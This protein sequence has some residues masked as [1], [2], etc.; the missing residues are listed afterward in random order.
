M[1]EEVS[2]EC[3]VCLRFKR[4]PSRP[5]TGLPISSNFNEC[6]AIDL[7]DRKRNKSFIIY[8][9]DTFSRLS[10]GKIIK[11]KEPATVIKALIDIWISGVV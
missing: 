10:R 9:V 8:A 3:T 7:K 4:T 1:I 6:V 2:R 5:K 11:N